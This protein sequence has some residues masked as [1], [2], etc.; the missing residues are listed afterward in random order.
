MEVMRKSMVDD[1]SSVRHVGPSGVTAATGMRRS[2]KMAAVLS[3]ESFQS[4][5][6]M[7]S[8]LGLALVLVEREWAM[9][10]MFP[11]RA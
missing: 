7:K 1:E 6:I 9:R 5:A 2:A 3:G 11:S 10:R 8:V 4:A